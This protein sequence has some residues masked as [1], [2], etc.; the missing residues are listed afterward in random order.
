MEKVVNASARRKEIM[1]FGSP[2]GAKLA[3]F[4]AFRP[5]ISVQ[6][7][8][9]RGAESRDLLFSKVVR[10]IFQRDAYITGAIA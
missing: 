2:P 3:C 8:A 9:C 1:A 10:V 4:D 6:S 5:Q 7:R